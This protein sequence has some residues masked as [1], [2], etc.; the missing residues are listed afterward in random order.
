VAFAAPALAAPPAA[1]D[2]GLHNAHCKTMDTPGHAKV[3]WTCPT[4]PG[5]CAMGTGGSA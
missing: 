3:P 5:G 2:F 4:H 1:A